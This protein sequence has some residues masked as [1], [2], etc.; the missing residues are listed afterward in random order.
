MRGYGYQKERPLN[1]A[2]PTEPPGCEVCEA[3]EGGATAGVPNTRFR[4]RVL[5]GSTK[6]YPWSARP[7]A[8]PSREGLRARKVGS[9]GELH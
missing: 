8:S 7:A 9:E 1:P 6:R 4:T 2:D 3:R 5:S